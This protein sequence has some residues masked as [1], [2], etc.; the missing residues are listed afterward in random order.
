MV[1]CQSKTTRT[2]TLL[3]HV[4]LST[5]DQLQLTTTAVEQQGSRQAKAAAAATILADAVLD[6]FQRVLAKLGGSV[7][8]GAALWKVA[9]AQWVAVAPAPHG[10]SAQ[11][12]PESEEKVATPSHAVLRIVCFNPLFSMGNGHAAAPLVQ[13]CRAA[14]SLVDVV[15]V[16]Q[17]D[18]RA[19]EVEGGK[20]TPRPQR[21]TA[22]H[23][24]VHVSI[25][26]ASV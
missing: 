15:S 7:W 13:I 19:E 3:L 1:R 24:E 23:R 25:R 18:A 6:E 21:E 22:Q 26:F 12:T 5:A 17:P 16:A 8:S 9:A 14:A 11:H 4:Y 2:K 10:D 20:R